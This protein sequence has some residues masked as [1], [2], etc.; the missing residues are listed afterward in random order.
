M[1]K[2]YKPM[3]QT[4]KWI[5]YLGGTADKIKNFQVDGDYLC[6][7]YRKCLKNLTVSDIEE[8]CETCAPKK[9]IYRCNMIVFFSKI[10]NFLLNRTKINTKKPEFSTHGFFFPYF[11]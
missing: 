7:R 1:S 5:S 10:L 3:H 9:D 4:V 8:I 6:S 2:V 11:V